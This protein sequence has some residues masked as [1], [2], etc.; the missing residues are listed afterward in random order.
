MLDP[1]FW[2]SAFPDKRKKMVLIGEKYLL[3]EHNVHKCGFRLF[4]YLVVFR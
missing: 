1:D 4:V 3:L 2:G